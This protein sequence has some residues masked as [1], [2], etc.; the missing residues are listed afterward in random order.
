MYFPQWY[1]SLSSIIGFGFNFF[2]YQVS[3]AILWWF[4]VRNISSNFHRDLIYLF[5]HKTFFLPSSCHNSFPT[6]DMF[7]FLR[8]FDVK[9]PIIFGGR[10]P[11]P[12]DQC[13]FPPFLGASPCEVFRFL[14]TSFSTLW[15]KINSAPQCCII[16]TLT[17]CANY[18]HLILVKNASMSQSSFSTFNNLSGQSNFEERT[19]T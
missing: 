10:K 13:Q 6:E 1:Q 17:V 3:T 7:H 8:N 14:S 16:L 2:Q 11:V 9:S 4:M 5:T 15:G 19:N 18:W 12:W